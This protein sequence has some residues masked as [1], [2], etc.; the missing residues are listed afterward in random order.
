MA[1][2]KSIDLSAALALVHAHQEEDL[3][4]SKYMV[5][6]KKSNALKQT[7]VMKKKQVAPT[8]KLVKCFNKKSVSKREIK[9]CDKKNKTSSF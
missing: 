5:K 2:S 4:C 6:K 9:K 3:I 7:V 1:V 8:S